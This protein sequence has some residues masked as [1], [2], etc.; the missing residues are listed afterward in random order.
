MAP[1][2]T[3][4]IEKKVVLRVPRAKVWRALADAPRF[5]AWFGVDLTGASFTLGVRVRGKITH[6]GYEHLTWE[7]VI[8]R[9]EPERL[10]SWRWHPYAV[11][12]KKDYSQE[13]MTLV[14]FELR[15]VPEGTLL[16]VVE[17]G[18]DQIPAAR[19]AEAWRMNDQGWASQME[20][21]ERHVTSAA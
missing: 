7:A 17:S 3:D 5:G 12:P 2:S 13:P 9:M 21:I 1:T 19:R 8:E 14:V 6:R 15:D 4:R 20:N 10:L 16:T 18:F 11:D